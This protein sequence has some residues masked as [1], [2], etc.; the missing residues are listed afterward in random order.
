MDITFLSIQS[1]LDDFSFGGSKT[2]LP[3]IFRLRELVKKS[4][5]SFSVG[6]IVP[7]RFLIL[8]RSRVGSNLLSSLLNQHENIRLFGKLFN[9]NS[10]P[11]KT[12]KNRARFR[13]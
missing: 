1:I 10:L 3:I 13:D 5:H 9:L 11:R 12:L 6:K 4:T 8:G 7:K 2:M